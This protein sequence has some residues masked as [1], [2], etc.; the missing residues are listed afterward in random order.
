[1]VS[2][3]LKGSE[4]IAAVCKALDIDSSLVRKVIIEADARDVVIVHIS[5]F[6]DERLLSVDWNTVVSNAVIKK[7]E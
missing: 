1:M 6:T 4:F 2:K 5:Q 3:L 7:S